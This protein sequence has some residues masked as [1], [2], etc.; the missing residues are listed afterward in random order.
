MVLDFVLADVDSFAD[1]VCLEVAIVRTVRKRPVSAPPLNLALSILSTSSEPQPST[2]QSQDQWFDFPEVLRLEDLQPGQKRRRRKKNVDPFLN[3][4]PAS[5]GR[6]YQ[7]GKRRKRRVTFEAP[8]PGSI[9]SDPMFQ[10][11]KRTISSHVETE[12]EPSKPPVSGRLREKRTEPLFFA[13]EGT[14]S[15]PQKTAKKQKKPGRPSKNA[16]VAVKREELLG[17]E[18]ITPYQVERNNGVTQPNLD[19]TDPAF[20]QYL[21]Q[22]FNEIAQIDNGAVSEMRYLEL[23]RHID[24]ERL[25]PAINGMDRERKKPVKRKR[26]ATAASGEGTAKK[27][28]VRKAKV[29]SKEAKCGMMADGESKSERMLSSTQEIVLSDHTYAKVALNETTDDAEGLKTKP[30]GGTVSSVAGKIFG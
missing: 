26:K 2:S 3:S 12:G 21:K 11:V 5:N 17:D 8:L 6:E 15:S 29:A 18:L 23:I 9:D 19:S 27:M 14:D 20:Q 1:D 16:N 25:K 10:A 24:V 22:C 13:V 30:L 4:Q 7:F 28:R